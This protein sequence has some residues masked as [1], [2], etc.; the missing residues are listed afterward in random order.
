MSHESISH[1]I[2]RTL[3][4]LLS[5]REVLI[6]LILPGLVGKVELLELLADCDLLL[7]GLLLETSFALLPLLSLDIFLESLGCFPLESVTFLD[8][9]SQL[10]ELLDVMG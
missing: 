8:V 1:Y 5:S 3:P 7:L 6:V 2:Y 4:A 9:A 10:F